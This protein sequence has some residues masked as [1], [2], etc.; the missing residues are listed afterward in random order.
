MM[1]TT[2][3]G[4]KPFAGAFAGRDRGNLLSSATGSV[5]AHALK[6][7]QERGELFSHVGDE[8]HENQILGISNPN[9]TLTFTLTLTPTLTLTLT[10]TLTRSTR[11]RS[12]G[13]PPSRAT[14]RSTRARSSSLPTCAPHARR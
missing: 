3:A 14:S 8:V 6:S 13:S 12:S 7:L 5:T 4:Y 10:L 2:F 1:S 9:L 11:T